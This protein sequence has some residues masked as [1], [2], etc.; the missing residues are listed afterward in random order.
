ME[1]TI[2][3]M[4][5]YWALQMFSVSNLFSVFIFQCYMVRR[6]WVL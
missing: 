4:K 3:P 1:D 2:T 5:L 6:L